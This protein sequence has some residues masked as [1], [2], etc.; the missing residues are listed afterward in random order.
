MGDIY[1]N[2]GFRANPF[3]KRSSEQELEFINDIFY[4]PNYYNTLINDLESGDSRFIIGHRGHG[5]T[6]IINK[7][8]EDL[9]KK[10]NICVVKI[11]RFDTIPLKDNEKNFLF[12]INRKIIEKIVYFL[13][14]NKQFLK[15][16]SKCQKEDLALLISIFYRPVSQQEFQT[17]LEEVH[18][19]KTIN[20]Y[21][22]IYNF[23]ICD[24]L[25]KGVAVGV[26]VTSDWIRNS[27]GLQM[28]LE[29]IANKEYFKKIELSKNEKK[30]LTPTEFSLDDLKSF[31]YKTCDLLGCI[32][33]TKA[34][35]LFDK[36]DEKSDLLNDI[37]K[38]SLFIKDILSDTEFLMKDTI[39][40]GFTLWAELK[41]ELSGYVRF[42]KFGIIDVRWNDEDMEPLI[43][44]RLAYY[45]LD[46]TNVVK[47]KDLIK[48]QYDREIII[49]LSNKS[50]RDLIIILF[51]ILKEQANRKPDVQSIE[52]AAISKALKVFCKHYD[53]NSNIPSKSAKNQDVKSMINK[54]LFLKSDSF[55][56]KEF[57]S[58]WRQSQRQSL[59]EIKT[60][61][62]YKLIH[63]EDIPNL[64]GE[65]VYEIIEP[66]I[67]YLIKNMITHIE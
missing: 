32:N 43:D 7:I 14:K 66:R 51:E 11:D 25:N 40:V 46:K 41:N 37:S 4:S 65:K 53:Y 18:K 59:N 1:N 62:G 49:K 21:K 38:I 56:E 31:L 29:D 50:P 47:F 6:S 15:N 28:S 20:F 34:V 19:I 36:I 44:K 17:A 55:T 22:R 5:K 35:V 54:L 58:A 30:E 24:L 13:F 3:S 57:S 9:N 27:L 12:L 2:L 8:Y 39:A 10:G 33:L 23:I 45:S 67:S 26:A 61:L 48:S 60:M 52:D 16:L 42:D 64:D 63:E